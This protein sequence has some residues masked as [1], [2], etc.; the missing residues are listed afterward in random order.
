MDHA[1]PSLFI[2]LARSDM[3]LDVMSVVLICAPQVDGYICMR[4]RTPLRFLEN[5]NNSYERFRRSL[6]QWFQGPVFRAMSPVQPVC[7]CLR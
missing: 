3:H 7:A 5:V 6:A 4:D 2:E 1:I